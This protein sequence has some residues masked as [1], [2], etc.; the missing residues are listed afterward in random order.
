MRVC[1]RSLTRIFLACS[2][3]NGNTLIRNTSPELV[4]IIWVFFFTWRVLKNIFHSEIHGKRSP[5]PRPPLR[6]WKTR[7]RQAW[8]PDPFRA[9][10]RVVPH[11]SE[12]F[13]LHPALRF[14]GPALRTLCLLQSACAWFSSKCLKSK[15][16]P[17]EKDCFLCLL[18]YVG[19]R[20]WIKAG[21]WGAGG[22]MGTTVIVST[23]TIKLKISK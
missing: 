16:F 23:V 6:D 7:T 4:G 2:V 8:H 5:N 1:S 18:A 20:I 9:V 19:G 17:L 15:K 21:W 12:G 10:R 13:A 11:F 14:A 22:R 3:D